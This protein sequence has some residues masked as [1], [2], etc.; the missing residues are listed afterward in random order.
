M[1]KFVSVI[2][3]YFDKARTA[4]AVAK[5]GE[6]PPQYVQCLLGQHEVLGGLGHA[7][8]LQGGREIRLHARNAPRIALRQHEHRN[9][10]AV[11]LRH[12]A[13]GVLGSRAVLHTERADGLAGR[14]ARDRVRHVQ[15][16]ALLAHDDRADVLRGSELNQVIHRVAAQNLHT[17]SLHDTRYRLANF[18]GA[19]A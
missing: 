12:A 16:D 11:T 8:H 5:L 14:D 7:A 13:I 9:A 1:P 18:H 10:L 15:A 4:A 3:G 6:C 2:G 17:L 19:P